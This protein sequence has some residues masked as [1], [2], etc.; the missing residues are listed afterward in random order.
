[1]DDE[2]LDTAAERILDDIHGNARQCGDCGCQFPGPGP[3]CP[4]CIARHN[5]R[6]PESTGSRRAPLPAAVDWNVAGP[7]LLAACEESL[8]YWYGAGNDDSRTYRARERAI[9]DLLRT[10]IAAAKGTL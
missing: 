5:A 8:D 3:L 10:A 4:D 1:M 7:M 9:F 6:L 2:I